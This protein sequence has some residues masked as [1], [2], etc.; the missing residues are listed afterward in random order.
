[1]LHNS[2]RLEKHLFHSNCLPELVQRKMSK[3]YGYRIPHQSV[4]LQE[5]GHIGHVLP[6]DLGIAQKRQLIRP[7]SY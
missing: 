3:Y 2:K 1:M 6:T 7:K 4:I 5:T